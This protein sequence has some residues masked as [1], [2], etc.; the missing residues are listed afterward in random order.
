M[1]ASD[2]GIVGSLTSNHKLMSKEIVSS[3]LELLLIS[4]TVTWTDFFSEGFSDFRSCDSE[5][6]AVW[7]IAPGTRDT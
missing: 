2:R 3:E 7:C 4:L 1:S 5:L 6:R